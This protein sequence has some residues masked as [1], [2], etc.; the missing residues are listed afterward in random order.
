MY[1]KITLLGYVGIVKDLQY[2]SA[3]AAVFHFQLATKYKYNKAAREATTWHDI[4]LFGKFAEVFS[5][6]ILS[7]QIVFIEG[8][9]GYSSYETDGVKH[10]RPQVFAEIIRIISKAGEVKDEPNESKEAEPPKDDKFT[11]DD[12]P[13]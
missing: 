13:F 4:V 1:N 7:R 2:T 6:M 8:R 10:I 12:I 3:G 11:D 9:M 5:K